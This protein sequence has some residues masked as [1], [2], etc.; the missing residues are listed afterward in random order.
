MAAVEQVKNN[1]G[2]S[3]LSY[4]GAQRVPLDIWDLVIDAA[5]D[6]LSTMKACAT[7]CRAFL[8]RSRYHLFKRVTVRTGKVAEIL[9]STFQRDPDIR[10][11][12]RELQLDSSN[13][14]PD[15][16]IHTVRTLLPMLFNLRKLLLR[17]MQLSHPALPELLSM[18]RYTV[19]SLDLTLCKFDSFAAFVRLVLALPYIKDLALNFISFDA[20]QPIAVAD[21]DLQLPSMS[22]IMLSTLRLQEHPLQRWMGPLL[23]WLR[24]TPTHSSLRKLHLRLAMCQTAHDVQNL[25]R[26][27]KDSALE[28]LV[29]DC[30]GTIYIDGG[31]WLSSS[32]TVCN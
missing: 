19:S 7:T 31:V 21:A 4:N 14:V 17:S 23:R 12:I 25:T 15:W 3:A 27:A 16:V 32:L 20:A 18:A 24:N 6:D 10:S 9:I 2:L 29:L 1:Q 30:G 22:E 8:H 13:P 5:A 26:F 11:A 28:T